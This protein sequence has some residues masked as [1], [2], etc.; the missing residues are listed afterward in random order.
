VKLIHRQCRIQ[1]KPQEKIRFWRGYSRSKT[2]YGNKAETRS[3]KVS[4]FQA[5]TKWTKKA[6]GTAKSS[7][8]SGRSRQK[9]RRAWPSFL[10]DIVSVPGIF[11][12]EPENDWRSPPYYLRRDNVFS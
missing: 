8:S 7:Q 10:T 9:L 11:F 2:I 3:S 6:G 1:I 5:G 4:F 12:F